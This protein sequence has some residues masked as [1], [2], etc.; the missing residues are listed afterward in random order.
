VHRPTLH[1]YTLLI[2]SKHLDEL[3]TDRL[4]ASPQG[5]NTIYPASHSG[6]T[7][8]LSMHFTSMPKVLALP[9]WPTKTKSTGRPGLAFGT[10]TAEVRNNTEEVFHQNLELLQTSPEHTTAFRA[11]QSMVFLASNNFLD[12]AD[13]GIREDIINWL[14][15]ERNAPLLR[16]LLSVGG[17]TAES[18]LEALYPYALQ[19]QSTN[20]IKI[21][22]DF[23]CDP[24]FSYTKHLDSYS[25]YMATTALGSACESR[26]FELVCLFWDAHENT[27]SSLH[28]KETKTNRPC[29][30]SRL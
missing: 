17:P 22:I 20:I 9:D 25:S 7:A 6:P 11:L 10:R 8:D 16:Q 1:P 27:Q 23:G 14:Q 4:L 21:F 3:G 18:T 5:R 2:A 26:N 30:S 19:G 28:Q 24:N 29:K 15:E 13:L 12:S